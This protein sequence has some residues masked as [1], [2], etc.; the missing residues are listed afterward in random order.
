[1]PKPK[2]KNMQILKLVEE[3]LKKHGNILASPV[4]KSGNFIVSPRN[5][6]M[7]FPK[8]VLRRSFVPKFL[9]SQN[10]PKQ[11]EIVI[12]GDTDDDK[13]IIFVNKKKGGPKSRIV[14]LKNSLSKLD[15]R[16][17]NMAAKIES[18]EKEN[19]KLRFQLAAATVPRIIQRTESW[20]TRQIMDWQENGELSMVVDDFVAFLDG[21]PNEP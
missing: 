5:V 15:K 2:G 12:L 10:K 16:N 19:N 17:E 11:D 4:K 1:M 8:I 13:S 7:I 20:T 3:Q 21:L 6:K 18:L 14:A 9:E